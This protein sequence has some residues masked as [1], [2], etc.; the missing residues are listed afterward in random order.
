[1]EMDL[2]GQSVYTLTAVDV[3]TGWT[4]CLA[5]PNKTQ[6]AVYNAIKALRL[7][8]PFPLLGIDCDNESKFINDHL[9]RYCLEE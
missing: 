9:C 5:I 8:P 3:A 1:M 2:A 7:R 6:I 4:E